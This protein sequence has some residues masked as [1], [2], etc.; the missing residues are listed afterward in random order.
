M[1]SPSSLSLLPRRNNRQSAATS[2]FLQVKNCHHHHQPHHH[3][4]RPNNIVVVDNDDRKNNNPTIHHHVLTTVTASSRSN[5]SSSSD[6]N[7][8]LLPPPQQQQ[9]GNGSEEEKN[10]NNR[11]NIRNNDMDDDYDDDNRLLSADVTERLVRGTQLR[12]AQMLQQ[13][14]FVGSHSR[15]LLKSNAADTASVAIDT[16]RRH[17]SSVLLLDN[18]NDNDSSNSDNDDTVVPQ[19][20]RRDLRIGYRIIGCGGYSN[21]RQVLGFN[22]DTPLS[23]QFA[24]VPNN[25]NNNSERCNNTKVQQVQMRRQ[26]TY[27]IKHLN[28]KLSSSPKKLAIGAKDLIMEAHFLSSLRHDNIITLRGWNAGGAAGFFGSSSSET[29]RSGGRVDGVFLVLDRLSE[30]LSNRIATMRK[31]LRRGAPEIKSSS[32]V[33][34]RISWNSVLMGKKSN[35]SNAKQQHRLATELFAERLQYAIKVASAVEYLHSKR[36]VY[37]DLKPAN[38]GFDAHTDELKVFD[39]GLATELPQSKSSNPDATFNLAGNTGTSRYMAVEVIR[40]QPYNT[41]A[42]VFSY[43]VLLWELM[44]LCKPYEGLSGQQIKEHVSGLGERPGIP[45]TWPNSL[46]RILRHGW[47]DS[48]TDRPTIGQIK[49]VLLDLY[50]LNTSSGSSEAYY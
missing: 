18:D 12:V 32:K 30:T 7:P 45:K 23:N 47:T 43:S 26:R 4:H 31:R 42:D 40:K 5:S 6:A 50:Q 28:P 27:V 19:F 9:R 13:S 16:I 39:F 15:C 1:V 41:K 36:I 37:R 3:H 8:T 20:E 14:N 38:V 46:R 25:N 49:K 21:I 35:K 34:G 17:P 48:L 29:T 33:K 24:T 22:I 11:N 10:N 2:A 44:S